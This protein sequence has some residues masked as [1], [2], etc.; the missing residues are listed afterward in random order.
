MERSMVYP[1]AGAKLI[2][3]CR[4]LHFSFPAKYRDFR[5]IV[6]FE[7]NLTEELNL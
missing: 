1:A 5:E 4:P 7:M 2:Q 6:S 3:S